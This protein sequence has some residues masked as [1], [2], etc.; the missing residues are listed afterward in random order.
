MCHYIDSLKYFS[1]LAYTKSIVLYFL[2]KYQ[3]FEVIFYGVPFLFIVSSK[4][5]MLEL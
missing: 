4:R 1:L 3:R 2:V 5:K